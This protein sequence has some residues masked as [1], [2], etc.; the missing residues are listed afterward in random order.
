MSLFLVVN[1]ISD[2]INSIGL[3]YSKTFFSN[4]LTIFF[5][6]LSLEY[7]FSINSNEDNGLVLAILVISY[8]P[9]LDLFIFAFWYVFIFNHFFCYKTY[10]RK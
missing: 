10:F 2:L 4:N 3:E 7:L 8:S 5:F 6:A 1:F 9:L